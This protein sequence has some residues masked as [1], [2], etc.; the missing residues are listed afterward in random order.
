MS[1]L[2]YLM[3]SLEN[4]SEFRKKKIRYRDGSNR[5]K[6]CKLT[7]KV[8]YDRHNVPFCY[9]PSKGERFAIC[10]DGGGVVIR[11]GEKLVTNPKNGNCSTEKINKVD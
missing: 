4:E 2:E 9:D 5:I 3:E 11:D 1:V 6:S 10:K 7:D 8:V